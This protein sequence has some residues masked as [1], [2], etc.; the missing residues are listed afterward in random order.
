MVRLPLMVVGAVLNDRGRP[1]CCE[2]WP[3]NMA[4]VSTLVLVAKCVHQRFRVAKFCVVADR[5]MISREKL[6]I[7]E[8]PAFVNC[9]LIKFSGV[10]ISCSTTL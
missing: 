2:M 4:D 6:K 3:G 10:W 1:I 7:L 8:D 5:G 9:L